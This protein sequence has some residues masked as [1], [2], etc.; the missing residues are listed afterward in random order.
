MD[1]RRRV[2]ELEKQLEVL[3]KEK[4]A[5]EDSAASAS[6]L[7]AAM[8]D[9]IDALRAA[10]G[11]SSVERELAAAQATVAQQAKQLSELKAQ[12]DEHQRLAEAQH[13][14]H[15]AELEALKRSS[16]EVTRECDRLRGLLQE[17]QQQQQQQ[18]QQQ[19]QQQQVP[20]V[21]LAPG[22]AEKA[23]GTLQSQVVVLKHSLAD[24][25]A[26]LASMEAMVAG[27]TA[28]L[29]EKEQQCQRVAV[30]E[31]Q[32]A[33]AQEARQTRVELLSKRELEERLRA[34]QARCASL[35]DEV[36]LLHQQFRETN[37]MLQYHSRPADSKGAAADVADTTQK[38]I[39]KLS[40]ERAD[41][42]SRFMRCARELRAAQREL[43]AWKAD[44]LAQYVAQLARFE[45]VPPAP[46]ESEASTATSGGG[47]KGAVGFLAALFRSP[48][49]SPAPQ[50]PEGFV[51]QMQRVLEE[52]LLKN[53]QLQ[54]DVIAI[55]EECD[56]LTA[57]L[58]QQQQQEQQDDHQQQQ[59][60]QSTP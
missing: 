28:E 25:K 38:Q 40:V 3:R 19:Q 53:A 29:Q 52:S 4:A 33:E 14:E 11:T 45:H 15:E 46:K 20:R 13:K 8:N 35:Q 43:C 12:L 60:K 50:V 55:A 42:E 37:D 39:A 54:H 56:A 21:T 9:E 51:A 32:L 22:S 26:E 36:A 17:A 31:K 27:L 41:A 2:D 59:Q 34:E 6:E 44:T 57:K 47:S 18:K 16:E 49:A 24:K 1:D 30:L 23:V 5:L 48:A 7:I 10:N 58:Q